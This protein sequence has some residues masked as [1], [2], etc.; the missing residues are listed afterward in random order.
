KVQNRAGRSLSLPAFFKEGLKNREATDG[1]TAALRCELSKVGVPV[2]WRKGDKALKPS[3]KY[4]MRQED[5]AAELLIRDLEVEDTGEYTCVCGDQKTSAVLTVHGK[6]ATL[7][8]DS[9]RTSLFSLSLPL[10][11]VHGNGAF[12]G[13]GCPSSSASLSTHTPRVLPLI[14]PPLILFVTDFRLYI[15]VFVY[16]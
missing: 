7:R 9:S 5:T 14:L 12:L 8:W 13:G 6:K 4:R 3:E 16:F 11:L 2:E 1:A 15:V 10:A